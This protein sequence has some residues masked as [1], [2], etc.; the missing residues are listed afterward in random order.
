[1]G[2][3]MGIEDQRNYTKECIEN[4]NPEKI[5]DRLLKIE[6]YIRYWCSK[7]LNYDQIMN[8]TRSQRYSMIKALIIID[9]SQNSGYTRSYF[10][11]IPVN[12][13]EQQCTF[14]CSI[15][16][17]GSA[18]IVDTVTGIGEYYLNDVIVHVRPSP[19]TDDNRGL[20]NALFRNFKFTLESSVLAIV[21]LVKDERYTEAL[22]VYKNLSIGPRV[23]SV[24]TQNSVLTEDVQEKLGVFIALIEL[25]SPTLEN[26]LN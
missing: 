15:A 11:R 23:F 20:L 1:M 2:N 18:K 17:Y 19:E 25:K 16:K 24:Y 14:V 4:A 8:E 7:T 5:I 13:G 22:T 21:N 26:S 12:D 10:G 3:I 6:G 9:E